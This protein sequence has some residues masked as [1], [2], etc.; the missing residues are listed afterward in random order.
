MALFRAIVR[1]LTGG[2][3]AVQAAD[4]PKQ[5]S[6]WDP[7][8]SWYSSEEEEL[9]ERAQEQVWETLEDAKVSTRKRRVLF[10]GGLRLTLPQA[11]GHLQ[12]I[13]N[14]L[15][16]NTVEGA[17]LEWLEENTAPGNVTQ[18]HMDAHDEAIESWIEEYWKKQDQMLENS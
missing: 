16:A 2:K 12:K 11:I 1:L 5:E 17:M 8:T 3:P 7:S 10:P 6:S 15:S 4:S 14:R 18:K 13:H 9:E